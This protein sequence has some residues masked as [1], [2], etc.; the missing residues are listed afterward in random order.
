MVTIH[1]NKLLF[2]SYHGVHEEEKLIGGEFEVNVSIQYHETSL[3]I[4]H[5]NETINYATV[6]EMVK[7]RMQQP[8]ELLETI[9]TELATEILDTFSIAEE[10]NISITKLHP[11]IVA[12]QGSVGVSFS[13][14]RDQ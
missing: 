3:P 12:I 7:A 11:P 10:I 1:L 2:H 4:K 8:T 14:K 13:L 5:L 6:F 9:A